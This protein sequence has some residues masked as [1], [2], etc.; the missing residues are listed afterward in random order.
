M[1][2]LAGWD[3]P[4]RT[5]AVLPT[6]VAQIIFAMLVTTATIL[7]R[8]IVDM[9]APGAGPLAL[10]HPAV[11][12]ATLFSRWFAGLLTLAGATAYSVMFVMPPSGALALD[13]PAD[14]ARV[15][16]N[17]VVMLF[18]ILLLETFRR[19]MVRANAERDRQIEQG[20]LL[21]REL[22]HR[23][24]NN[25]MAV[26][27]VLEMHRQQS[28]DPVVRDELDSAIRRVD[29]IATAHR[30]LYRG[31]GASEQVEMGHYLGELCGALR[32]ALLPSDRLKLR[33]AI[34]SVTMPRDRAI[35]IGLIVNELVT[36]AVR[37]AFPG[38]RS[39]TIV[40][41]LDAREGEAM[42]TVEDDGCGIQAPPREGSLGRR[43]IAAFVRQAEGEF[44]TESSASG[45]RCSLVLR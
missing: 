4:T 36:N 39:G 9:F 32:S 42:L 25:F 43:L 17:V 14:R 19:A 8:M 37:H 10:I 6:A 40:V 2:W 31:D 22:D 44:S 3:F 26:A 1:N 41:S 35:A 12:I 20:Q 18:T 21:L 13:N 45:T 15:I 16:V 11:M 34:D 7:L 27:S 33:T 5:A 29:G 28:K 38:G 30:F 24:K 23:V